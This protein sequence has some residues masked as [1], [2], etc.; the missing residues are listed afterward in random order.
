MREYSKPE[1]VRGFYSELLA[2]VQRLPGVRSAGAVSLLPLGGQD[3]SGTTTIDTQSVPA[4][5]TTP[6]ADQRV[7]TPDYFKA[8]GISLVRGRFFEA[9]RHGRCTGRRHYR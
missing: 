5:D 2:R 6:E 3:C 8:M 1:Q 4:E 7:A 9:S